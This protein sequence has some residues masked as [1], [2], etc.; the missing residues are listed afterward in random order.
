MCEFIFKDNNNTC[1]YCHGDQYN[2]V[3]DVIAE[4][5]SSHEE[6]SDANTFD[7]LENL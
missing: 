1:G 6:N 2:N 5:D 3:E 4:N 7:L